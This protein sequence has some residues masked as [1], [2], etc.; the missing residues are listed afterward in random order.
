MEIS[1]SQLNSA[2]PPLNSTARQPAET[3]TAAKADKTAA[4]NHHPQETTHFSSTRPGQSSPAVA[5]VNDPFAEAYAKLNPSQKQQFDKLLDMHS[6]MPAWLAPE[7][8]AKQPNPFAGNVKVAY[9]KPEEQKM[10]RELLSNGTLLRKGSDKLSILEHLSQ[11][12][13]DDKNDKT[14]GPR[15]VRDILRMLNPENISELMK[16]AD[17][18]TYHLNDKGQQKQDGIPMPGG[19]G[20]ITQCPTHYTCGAATMQVWMRLNQPE[21][22][23]RIAHDLVSKGKAEIKGDSLKPARGS[24]DFHEGDKIYDNELYLTKAGKEDR[25]DL[26]IILQSAL[27]DEIAIGNWQ[28]YDVNADS[29]GFWNVL[30][31]NSGGH[32]MYMQREMEQ[33]TGKPFEYQHNLNVYG[34]GGVSRFL[35][36]LSDRTPQD[37]LVAQLKNQLQA[38]KQVMI[39]YQTRSGDPMALHYVT[40]VGYDPKSDKFYYADTD[41]PKDTRAKMYTKTSQD[42]MDVL[43]CVI[44][45]K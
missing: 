16:R 26:D 28:P 40:V 25:S 18:M 21:E 19:L 42:M 30:D 1:A 45:P 5:F 37:Q 3:Q 38:G 6:M 4:L 41:E 27:M 31:G 9:L 17:K 13:T 29:G 23:V 14:S 33:L 36:N 39:A 44:Y 22:L 8:A 32:P 35:G 2:L 10:L 20:E 15:L 24:L 7:Q 12:A 34:L 43:R 11:L